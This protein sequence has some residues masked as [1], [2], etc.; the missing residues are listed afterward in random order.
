MDRG[1]WNGVWPVNSMGEATYGLLN[2]LKW[3]FV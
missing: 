1:E 2:G 3:G